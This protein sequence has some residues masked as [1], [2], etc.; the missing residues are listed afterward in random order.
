MPWWLA[1][2]HRMA[3]LSL[4]RVPGSTLSNTSLDIQIM[5]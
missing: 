4:V 2:L 5:K 3:W 1:N